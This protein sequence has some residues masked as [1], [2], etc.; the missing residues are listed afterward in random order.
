MLDW[1]SAIRAD[2]RALASAGSRMLIRSDDRDHHQ[3]FDQ[4]ERPATL[5]RLRHGS[6]RSEGT[7]PAERGRA[8]A[9]SLPGGVI[10]GK[11]LWGAE[12]MKAGPP[13]ADRRPRSP[14][15]DLPPA[16]VH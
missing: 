14:R 6:L 10:G 2:L 3:Q 5:M 13:G 9:H 16:K 15:M 8:L 12:T 1:H 11:G 4:R 7:A